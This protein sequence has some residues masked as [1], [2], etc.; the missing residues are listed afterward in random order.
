MTLSSVLARIFTSFSVLAR[1]LLF[2]GTRPD[3]TLF[4]YLPGYD[5]F[6]GTRPNPTL[7]R[8]SP[9][10]YIFDTH[11]DLTHFL[12]LAL[13]RSPI[14]RILRYSPRCDPSF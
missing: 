6:F 10:F 4:Q 5:P 7:F 9:G 1:I 2:S 11:P 12:V 8:D 3:P 14:L 13:I